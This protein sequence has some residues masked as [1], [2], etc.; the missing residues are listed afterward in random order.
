MPGVTIG[1]GVVVGAGSIVT[2][3]LP[4]NS[5]AAGVPA[6]IIKKFSDITKRWEAN[7]N[8]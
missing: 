6:K 4:A 1:D 2:K 3:D 8:N 5:L 7:I